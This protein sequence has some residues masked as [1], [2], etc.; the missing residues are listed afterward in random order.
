MT[1]ALS[2]APAKRHFLTAKFNHTGT[3]W[4][5][6]AKGC[7]KSKDSIFITYEFIP[8]PFSSQGSFPWP[9]GPAGGPRPGQEAWLQEEILFT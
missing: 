5:F 4:F 9:V 8:K 3:P 7:I 1:G 6:S 2:H